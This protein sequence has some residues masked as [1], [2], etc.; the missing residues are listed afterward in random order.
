MYV[1]AKKIAS[2]IKNVESI[3]E[4]PCDQRVKN[5]I[6]VPI[7]VQLDWVDP[8]RRTEVKRLFLRRKSVFNKD[9][10]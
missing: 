3:Q 7:I 1:E 6:E 5:D 9:W 2:V 4:D 10:T 8:E